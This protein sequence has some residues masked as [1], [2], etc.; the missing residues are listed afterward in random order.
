MSD[1]LV[2]KFRYESDNQ[3][4]LVNFVIESNGELRD[5]EIRGTLSS[6]DNLLKIQNQWIEAYRSFLK[7]KEIDRM[8]KVEKQSIAIIKTTFIDC[9]KAAYELENTFH[10]WLNSEQFHPFKQE[11]EQI[12]KSQKTSEENRVLIQTNQPWL[13]KLPL[14][15]W[16]IFQRYSCEVGLSLTENK[17]V[18][19]PLPP[20]PRAKV[21]ILAI[22]G[23]STKI[24]TKV[25]RELL[26][27]IPDAEI[28]W[29][30]QPQRRDLY[31][32]L[33]NPH[34]LDI[35]F[36]AGHSKSEANGDSGRISINEN[37][38]LSIGELKNA[39]RFAIRLG[40]KLA[41]FNSCDGLGL[42]RELAD[43][44]IPHLI[45]FRESVD[46]KV[47][48]EF[49]QHFLDAYSSDNSL[50]TSVRLAREKLQ[51]LEED[52]PCASWLPV[53]CQNPSD[54]PL[55]WQ[56]LRGSQTEA[57]W[58][59]CCQVMLALSTY[60]RLL[61][62]PLTD[63][64]ELG[65]ELE[66]IYVP[67]G[68]VERRKQDRRIGD[69]SPEQGSQF[70]QQEPEY[71]ITKTFKPQE[72]FEQVLHQGQSPKSQGKRLVIIG[73]PGAGKTTLLQKI[74]DWV[75]ENTIEDVPIWISLADLQRGQR[76]EGYLHQNWLEL[77][78]QTVRVPGATSSTLVQ[79]FQSGRVW[80]LLDGVDEYTANSVN[81]IL[82]LVNQLTDWVQ[83]A[84]VVLTCRLNLWEANKNALETFDTYRTLDFSYGNPQTSDQV[85]LFIRRWFIANS[86][87]GRR[88][89]SHL[90]EPGR[91]RIKNLVKNP[92]RLSLLC[93][94]WQWQQGK[95]PETRAELYRQFTEAVYKWK[96]G[97]F[98]TTKATEEELNAALGR[99]ARRSLD[100]EASW[101]RLPHHL[102]VEELGEFDAPLF[103]LA[104][105]L[106]WLNQV[107]V[108]A[109]NPEEPVY[110]FFHPTFQEYFAA[111]ATGNW[112]DF[113]QHDNHQP[114]PMQ[115]IY[116]IFQPQWKEPMILWLGQS[117]QEVLKQ[118]KEEFIK[119]LV[120]FTD[121]CNNFYWYRAFS[122]AAAG[123]AEYPDCSRADLIVEQL[124]TQA[125]RHQSVNSPEYSARLSLIA[126]KAKEALKETDHPR[127]INALKGIE[128]I[129]IYFLVEIATSS[130]DDIRA[131]AELVQNHQQEDVRLI[132][133]R[134]LLQVD[135][136]NQ[137]AT[138]TLLNM[139]RYSRSPWIYHR[140]ARGLPGNS[141]AIS[142]LQEIL[143]RPRH[144]FDNF[145]IKNILAEIGVGNP[146]ATDSLA[147]SAPTK[148]RTFNSLLNLLSKKILIIVYINFSNT[149][150]N[151]LQNR[152][153][154]GIFLGLRQSFIFLLRNAC[155]TLVYL[156]QKA[157]HDEN[158]HL[159][160]IEKL[161]KFDP[162][163]PKLIL[164][165]V[166]LLR[167]GQSPS[168]YK[169]A[170]QSLKEILRG[171]M[172]LVVVSG[173]RDCLQKGTSEERYDC[174]YEVIWHCA[175]H[176]AYPD[177]Y[178]AWHGQP[179]ISDA[180]RN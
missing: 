40:L 138:D 71:E 78:M 9:Q 15:R 168:V 128:P 58:R 53:I 135:P 144:P 118:E 143:G 123:I 124:V 151:L 29:S 33:W 60:K 177:F 11:L 72:F 20:K 47:A 115:G 38:S 12:L 154:R 88:L 80:L 161:A 114:A 175:Q 74:G 103:Q 133:A 50:Y 102:V 120:T 66:E 178:Q 46:D 36:F 95:L 76:L 160:F 61:N 170:A 147:A 68:L 85:G 87:S 91:S 48:R 23:D 56:K 2:L 150:A 57:T 19:R 3:N 41:I 4:L 99:L 111:S 105:Q 132:V 59:A 146:N 113:L 116:R 82:E 17:R 156:H 84:R 35:F 77:A 7:E 8:K 98:P 69:V 106:G 86:E 62:N 73:E 107:G 51:T 81:P 180:Q 65:L 16:E 64:N 97:I 145:E 112:H 137:D 54:A 26:E 18:E 1:L 163:N 125:F 100:L 136:G 110:A 89:R 121:G 22:I 172:C 45:V 83:R 152:T 171:Q 134:W 101:F 14:H 142:I 5:T 67:L 24:D 30:Q 79:M 31:Q 42:A 127:V 109:Q 166:E 165:L 70:Y 63:K 21:R 129:P 104:L 49:L 174:C 153:F 37:D 34:G 10:N 159:Q 6:A 126:D 39:L 25:D 94:T 43:L 44:Y 141:E 28:I 75:L 173:L 130:P 167:T 52:I 158:F 148:N 164:S 162:G 92:L 90:D 155:N 139:L 117:E 27:K 93:R 108:A 176:S 179:F 96:Q 32:K 140:A 149:K 122:L 55:T 157:N 131:L 119:A 13:W 169:Q